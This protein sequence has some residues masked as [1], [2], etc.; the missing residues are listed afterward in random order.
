MNYWIT[1]YRC[2]QR[3][4]PKDILDEITCMIEQ[5]NIKLNK[6]VVGIIK[7]KFKQSLL[8]LSWENEV[9]L[10]AFSKISITSIKNRV[11]LC[12]QTG[13][14]SRIYA[15]LLKLQTLFITGRIDVGII[16]VPMSRA[17]KMLGGNLASYERLNRELEIFSGTITMPIVIVGFDE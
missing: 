16:V 4:A 2:G 8:D 15:D 3:V 11:G 13:N 10:D 9:R 6:T 17:G 12:L 14:V 5:V 1:E 7:E